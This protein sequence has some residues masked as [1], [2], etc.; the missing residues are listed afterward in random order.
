VRTFAARRTL[1]A[2][3]LADFYAAAVTSVGIPVSEDSEVVRMFRLR[4]DEYRLACERQ[5][6]LEAEVGVRLHTHA[7]FLRL[8]TLPGDHRRFG[9]LW[10]FLKYC[11][12]ELYTEQ[13]GNFRGLAYFSR[14]VG[15]HASAVRSGWPDRD[16]RR[17]YGPE[18]FRRR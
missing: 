12:F 18:L 7:G 4:L 10:Q 15:T 11:G 14:S 8:Q 5:S 3:G 13:S 2:A 9:H 17:P 6:Q 16:H 1:G